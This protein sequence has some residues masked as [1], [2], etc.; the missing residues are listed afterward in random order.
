[1]SEYQIKYR[2][3]TKVIESIKEKVFQEWKIKSF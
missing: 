3:Y 1:M 2:Y